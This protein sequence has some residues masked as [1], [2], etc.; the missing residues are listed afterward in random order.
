MI[1]AQM[2]TTEAEISLHEMLVI[3]GLEGHYGPELQTKLKEFGM[4]PGWFDC[5]KNRT[6]SEVTEMQVNQ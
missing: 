1:P 3:A 4:H 2:F 6:R 5:I